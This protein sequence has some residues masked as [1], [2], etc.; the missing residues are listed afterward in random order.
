MSKITNTYYKVYA[1]G[2]VL[3]FPSASKAKEFAIKFSVGRKDDTL[4]FKVAENSVFTRALGN[5][6]PNYN[7][8]EKLA[9]AVLGR[10]DI[11]TIGGIINYDNK[12]DF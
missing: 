12:C 8:T 3:T 5:E 10:R 6:I 11:D 2:E 1:G 4:G 9:F 7:K